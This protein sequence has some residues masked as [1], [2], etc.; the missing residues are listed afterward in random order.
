MCVVSTACCVGA[1][2]RACTRA[3]QA[4]RR[5]TLGPWRGSGLSAWAGQ[6]PEGELPLSLHHAGEGSQSG[7]QCPELQVQPWS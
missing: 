1:V 7:E 5:L 4:E 3:R 6:H 2:H